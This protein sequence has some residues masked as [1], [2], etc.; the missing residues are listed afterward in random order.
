MVVGLYIN[1]NFK[2][3][4]AP[5]KAHKMAKGIKGRG[6]THSTSRG[7]EKALKKNGNKKVRSNAKLNLK[8][9]Y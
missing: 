3:G 8:K 7:W 4:V 5:R 6:K 2:K 9:D 1:L